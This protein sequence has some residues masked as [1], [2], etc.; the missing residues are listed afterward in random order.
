M[1]FIGVDL[2]WSST[3]RGMTGVCLVE[4]GRVI[5]SAL[6]KT[7]EEIVNWLR[8]NCG[9]ACLVAIDAPLIVVNGSGQRECDRL[10]SACFGRYEAGCYPANKSMAYFRQQTRG[11]RI[12]AALG[13][14]LDPWLPPTGPYRHAIEV[15]PHPSQVVLF[16]LDRTIKYKRRRRRSMEERRVAFSEYLRRMESLAESEPPLDVTSA[17][18][19]REI[20]S[21]L[22]NTAVMAEMNRLEDE[23]DAYFCAYLASYY[24]HHRT[25]RCRVIGSI[26]DGYIVTPVT[27]T[28]TACLD[29]EVTRSRTV[30]GPQT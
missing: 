3:G 29:A 24:G 7:D 15:Y 19:W 14:S 11:E 16:G 12:T 28:D 17:P 1:R 4:A 10:V 13:L 30:A 22:M 27:H 8:L 23:L 9:Q 2:A 25:D 20:H 18:R 5:E 6:L 26:E 21:G